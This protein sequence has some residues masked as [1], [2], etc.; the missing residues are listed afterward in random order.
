MQ[1]KTLLR[2]NLCWLTFDVSITDKSWV[3]IAVKTLFLLLNLCKGVLAPLHCITHSLKKS[4]PLCASSV[5]QVEL[6]IT[7]VPRDYFSPQDFL[8]SLIAGNVSPVPIST[9]ILSW[10]DTPYTDSIAVN[11]FLHSSFISSA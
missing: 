9:H 11:T 2:E 5:T 10:N 8:I 1:A 6:E 7:L 3:F 4:V